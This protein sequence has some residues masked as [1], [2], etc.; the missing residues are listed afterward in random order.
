VSAAAA[1][2]AGL[3]AR[4]LR[5]LG[6]KLV[7][8]FVLQGSRSIAAIVLARLLAPH[9]YGLAG[10]VL[11]FSSFVLVFSDLALGAAI[12]QRPRL[13]ERDRSTAFWTSAG[14]GVVF[15]LVGIALSGPLASFY[16]EPKVRPLFIALSFSFLLAS[17]GTTQ[18]AL[19]LRELSFRALE[20]CMMGGAVVGAVLGIAAA[21][22]GAGA[23]AIIVQQLTTA[24]VTTAALWACSSWRPRF[25]F[26]LAS[27][28]D[29][30]GFSGNVFGQRFLYYVMRN[31]DN[32]LV[33][34]FLGAAALGAYSIAYNVMLVPFNQVAGPVQE[35]LFPAFSRLQKDR[36]RMTAVWIRCGRLV[37]A[38][39]I[40][41]LL[42][43]IVVAPDF[44]AV[45]LGHRWHAAGPVLRILAWVGLL[46]SLQRLN[47]DI[48]QALDRTSLLL[49]FSIGAFVVNL[50][51]FVL[52]L[53]WGILGVAACFAVSSTLVEPIY[54][55]LTARALGVSV[56]AFPR[57]LVGVAEASVAMA[58]C[59]LAA[60][61]L[62][63]H[64]G[65]GP[66]GRLLAVTA[67]GI[68]LYVPLCAWRARE[69]SA[70]LRELR[71]RRPRPATAGT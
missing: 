28:R 10:M 11:V 64:A 6:W 33:G 27:L 48:L 57:S 21:I 26:S 63:V 50:G 43:L 7:S 62:L 19:L 29:L 56:L 40:P 5:G 36:E 9:D 37:A 38:V 17:L 25:A 45:V 1:S 58:C 20:L 3:R 70:E 71:A 41:A 49:R 18:S 66:A 60:R 13:E 46:Q 15:T 24:G 51:A 22:R 12:V 54:S 53:R 44:V 32:L 42:G 8:L 39:T 2:V 31:V 61:E 68:A 67:L 4:V 16:G 65:V 35:V 34:R 23:W 69:V 30:G 55:V 59:V 52:G 14:A 47:G